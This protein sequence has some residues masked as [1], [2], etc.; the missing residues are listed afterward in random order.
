MRRFLPII[1]VV[2]L[3]GL[4]VRLI[5]LSPVSRHASDEPKL[6]VHFI[7]AGQ[8]D[9]TLI[10]TPDDRNI[11]VDSGSVDAS[12]HVVSYLARHGVRRIDL[13]VIAHGDESSIGGL[14]RVL[15]RFGV[16]S[17]LDAAGPS[18]GQTHEQAVAAISERRI[19]YKRIDAARR[20]S[21]SNCV[22]IAV[23]WPL[24]REQNRL[25]EPMVVRF[26]YKDIGFLLAGDIEPTSEGYLL[27]EYHDLRSTVLR[28]ANHGDSGTTSNEFLQI[29]KPEY[30]VISAGSQSDEVRPDQETID[31]LTAAGS[32]V[33]RT[34]RDGDIVISTD[35]SRVWTRCAE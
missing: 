13:L 30:A 4:L 8:G 7:D 1:L 6:Y 19:D 5:T 29:V 33:L 28:V 22:D 16:S 17:V 23:V 26:G 14:P 9:C 24:E 35:G 21:V 12:D 25:G 32:K 2:V 34:D 31:R 10:H 11:L 20:L 15:D 3:L 27:A 18:A